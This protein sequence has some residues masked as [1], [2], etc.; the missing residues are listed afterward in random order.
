MGNSGYVKPDIRTNFS[1]IPTIIFILITLFLYVFGLFSFYEYYISPQGQA[2]FKLISDNLS[3]IINVGV[4]ITPYALA[5]LFFYLVIAI[6]FSWLLLFIISKIGQEVTIVVTIA[7]PIILLGIGALF[8]AAGS[9]IGLIF[10]VFGGILL[11]V[12]IFKFTALKRAGKFLEFSAQLSLDEKAVLVAPIILGLF[13]LISGLFMMASYW[14]INQLVITYLKGQNSDTVQNIGTIVAFIFEYFYLIIYLGISY[15]LNAMVI[16]YAGDW[17][18][19]LDPDLK[20]A[21]KDIRDVLPIIL[22]FAFAMATV[23]MIFTAFARGSSSQ[24]GGAA[25]GGR[26]GGNNL[27]GGLVLVI[28]GWLFMTIFG[29]IWAF[30][31]YF[32]LISIVQKKQNLTNSIKDSAKTMWH[33]FLDV[34]VA[35]TGYGPTMLIFAILFG[36]MWF[37]TGFGIGF[38]VFGSD[39][40]FAFVFG[41]LFI[42]LSTFPYTVISMPMNTS[43]KTFLYSYAQD[44]TEG[45]KKPS[46]LPVE[47]RDDFKYIQQN[48]N[49][50]KMRDPTQYNF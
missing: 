21:R 28:V 5:F 34:L 13:T 15:I 30:L 40:V 41:I 4:S 17:Y 38:F 1:N 7:A 31:N 16:S 32:T 46:K 20:S 22:K 14:E 10:L 36:L 50:R 12:L 45:F 48:V 24:I 35:E 26:R 29:A 23:Q 37:G 3:T 47:L 27:G 6:F 18:R 2:F 44:Y 39:I 11:L 33:S 19:G 8:I 43:F 9:L 49:K 42:V 25:Q